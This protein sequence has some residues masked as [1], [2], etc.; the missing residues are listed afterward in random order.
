MDLF[1]F[2]THDLVFVSHINSKEPAE[3]FRFHFLQVVSS[4]YLFHLSPQLYDWCLYLLDVSQD[5]LLIMERFSNTRTSWSWTS[6]WKKPEDKSGA[7]RAVNADVNT[8]RV[9]IVLYLHVLGHMFGA[10]LKPSSGVL[11]VIRKTGCSC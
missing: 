1:L 5:V 7:E 10:Q 3:L 6:V 11:S 9:F 4:F 8:C 2:S